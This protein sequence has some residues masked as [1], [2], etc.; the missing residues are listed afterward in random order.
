MIACRTIYKS[1]YTKVSVHTCIAVPLSAD[2][3]KGKD[4]LEATSSSRSLLLIPSPVKG[5]ND[6]QEMA[7]FRFGAGNTQYEPGVFYSARKGSAKNKR[8]KN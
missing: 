5:Q 8:G 6:S 2:R 7:D 1:V 3:P 4:P